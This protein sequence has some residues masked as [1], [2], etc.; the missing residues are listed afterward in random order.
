MSYFRKVTK[1][2]EMLA[3]CSFKEHWLILVN[4]DPDAMASAMAL[5]RIIS[6]RVGTV[7]IARI[8]TVTRPDNLAMIQA[9]RLRMRGYDP[10]ML[11][12][13][14]RFALVDS[15]PHH[16]PLFQGIAFLIIEFA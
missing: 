2:Q 12:R 9:T 8:N 6:R 7:D 13:Y 15:Q 10:A 11:S 3:L 16:S 5:K 4:A 1:I 14:A